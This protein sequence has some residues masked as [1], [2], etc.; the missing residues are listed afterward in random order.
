M[1]EDDWQPVIWL[2]N[3]VIISKWKFSTQISFILGQAWCCSPVNIK[4]DE[5]QATQLVLLLLLVQTSCYE[6]NLDFSTNF[7]NYNKK[8]E[9]NFFAHSGL[10][11]LD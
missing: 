6:V 4:T 9:Y 8:L 3:I 1:T 2:G 7:V 11:F 5:S 10:Q